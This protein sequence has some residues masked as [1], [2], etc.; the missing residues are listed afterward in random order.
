MYYACGFSNNIDVPYIINNTIIFIKKQ[1][2]KFGNEIY[3]NLST[4]DERLFE[5][6]SEK[7]K[8]WKRYL[9]KFRNIMRR[10]EKNYFR[11]ICDVGFKSWYSYVVHD[12]EE[13]LTR[14]LSKILFKQKS[15]CKN[16]ADLHCK[17]INF[18]NFS[19]NNNIIFQDLT[20]SDP[21]LLSKKKYGEFMKNLNLSKLKSSFYKSFFSSNRPLEI[22]CVALP[23]FETRIS[24][25]VYCFMMRT[26]KHIP[27][28]CLE[29][30]L[31]FMKFDDFITKSNKTTRRD[32]INSEKPMEKRRK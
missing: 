9:S 10:F 24:S 13:R 23:I 16:H 4:S 30:I 1:A 6:Y 32:E 19:V 25:F 15:L 22:C 7:W 8:L 11:D 17:K 12:I 14:Q 26:R 20:S 3:Q 5:I 2:M 28:L 29:E 18:S 27:L 21:I 31:S